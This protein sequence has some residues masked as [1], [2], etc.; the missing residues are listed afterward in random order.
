MN[1]RPGLWAASSRHLWA[2]AVSAV[3]A[4]ANGCVHTHVA[5]PPAA[6]APTKPDHEIGAETGTPVS[7]TPRGLMHDGGEEKIQKR[8]HAKGLLAADQ[9]TGQFN[10]QTR[11]AL[12][13]FQ[14]AEGLPTTGLPSYETVDH[15][16]LSLDLVFRTT[17]HPND[18]PP[19][20]RS[21]S[22]P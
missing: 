9:C 18:R 2:A 16:G 4:A 12:R 17:K 6:V 7:S 20:S 21:G 3:L 15:L 8:L 1:A 22:V 13:E 10:P 11:D 5:P 14:K 19:P